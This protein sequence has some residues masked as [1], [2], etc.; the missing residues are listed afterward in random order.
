MIAH[1]WK[2][3]FGTG[4]GVENEGLTSVVVDCPSNKH[5]TTQIG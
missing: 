1:S 3:H 2:K 4:Q 5:L